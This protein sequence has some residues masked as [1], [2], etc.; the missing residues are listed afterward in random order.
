MWRL[1]AALDL[2]TTGGC[3]RCGL[4]HPDL[5]DAVLVR[6]RDHLSRGPCR[7][8]DLSDEAAVAELAA[9]ALLE[10]L[11]IAFL[12]LC[13]DR[14]DAIV[15][16]HFDVTIRIRPWQLALITRWSPSMNSS[17]LMSRKGHPSAP[18]GA[19]PGHRSVRSRGHRVIAP[20]VCLSFDSLGS[21]C[22][23]IRLL[24][25][26]VFLASCSPWREKSAHLKGERSRLARPK[27]RS[28]SRR[29]RTWPSQTPGVG[30]W[31]IMGGR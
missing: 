13:R 11:S 10:L 20:G 14:E 9:I 31:F 1:S 4:R 19:Q 12:A 22:S 16:R 15:H 8:P 27:R 30:I 28:L 21:A 29:T 7:K 25:V 6:R 18:K 2:D 24:P 26:R 3:L 23:V 5:Q 17:T